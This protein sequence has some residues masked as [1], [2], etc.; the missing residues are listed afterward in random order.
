MLLRSAGDD[1]DVMME[2]MGEADCNDNQWDMFV[3]LVVCCMSLD[4]TLVSGGHNCI[5]ISIDITHLLD[6]QDTYQKER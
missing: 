1:D 3:M 5:T 2:Q 6:G 4:G